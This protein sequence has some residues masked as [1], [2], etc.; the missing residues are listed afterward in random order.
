[1]KATNADE[2]G[3][4]LIE[5]C[6]VIL[7]VGLLL[8][9][10]T[11][12]LAGSYRALAMRSAAEQVYQDF[13]LAS[14]RAVL[15]AHAWRVHIL[16]GGRSYDLEERAFSAE[17]D[18]PAWSLRQEWRVQLRRSVP[19]EFILGP[20]GAVLEWSPDGRGPSGAVALRRRSGAPGGY[21]I[22]LENGEVKL[23]ERRESD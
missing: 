4:T 11:P 10:A 17:Q 20:E 15:S 8:A 19:A 18:Q 9:T 21:E 23:D 16:I 12:H 5:L 6:F 14:R 2:S 22:H 7:I 13:T 1:M 3:L